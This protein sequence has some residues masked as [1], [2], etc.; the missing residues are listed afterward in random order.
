MTGQARVERGEQSVAGP[1]AV[2]TDC[3]IHN[4]GQTANDQDSS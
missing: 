3:R 1:P 4:E 2:A